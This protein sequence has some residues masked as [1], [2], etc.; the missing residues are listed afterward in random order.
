[1][2]DGN[3]M[4]R[5]I[6][7]FQSN[8][9]SDVSVL[10]IPLI[11]AT[12]YVAGPPPGAWNGN[13]PT[14][15]VRISKVIAR[16]HELFPTL[17]APLRYLPPAALLTIVGPDSAIATDT[18]T[19]YAAMMTFV[20]VPA[21]IA[22][23]FWLGDSARA[24]RRALLGAGLAHFLFPTVTTYY[25]G[26][27]NWQY[28]IGFVYL[29]L[30]VLALII[31]GKRDGRARLLWTGIASGLL[32]WTGLTQLIYGAIGTVILGYVYLRRDQFYSF[33]LTGLAGFAAFAWY[34]SLTRGKYG[35]P[36]E[37][38]LQVLSRR[39]PL[40]TIPPYLTVKKL[41]AYLTTPTKVVPL[42]LAGF[43]GVWYL[44]SSDSFPTSTPLNALVFLMPFA[45]LCSILVGSGYLVY[46]FSVSTFPLMIATLAAV[47][48]DRWIPHRIHL[49]RRMDQRLLAIGVF[50]FSLA[51]LA[52]AYPTL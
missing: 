19:L 3:S 30:M 5:R 10:F 12:V 35:I 17:H 42:L 32:I 13:D 43:V 45:M 28:E 51:Y 33:Y 31:A 49:A 24:G 52:L 15:W 11:L 6:S 16:S 22:G 48:P 7:Q 18:V 34:L 26:G 27:G 23:V 9:A 4:R 8:V 41:T 20:G 39:Y 14:N 44:R 37:G 46:F 36:T 29:L 40:G 47:T 25:R 2:D 38:Y 50:V 21:G 1:M